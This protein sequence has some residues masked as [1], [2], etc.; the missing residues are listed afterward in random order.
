MSGN[1]V[2][3][4][5]S[6]A[7]KHPSAVVQAPKKCTREEVDQKKT[8]KLLAAEKKWLQK[9]NDAIS[10]AELESILRAGNTKQEQE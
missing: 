7:N 4:H 8:S 5:A 6:N 3:T 10:I 2:T 9:Q 1:K